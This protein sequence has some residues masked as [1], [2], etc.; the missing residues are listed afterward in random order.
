MQEKEREGEENRLSNYLIECNSYHEIIKF[1]S[2]ELRS[3]FLEGVGRW[4]F[5]SRHPEPLIRCPSQI[6]SE[7]LLSASLIMLKC[8]Q[9]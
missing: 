7:C 8:I 6:F 9:L 4:D 3:Q 1:S 5:Y 2:F